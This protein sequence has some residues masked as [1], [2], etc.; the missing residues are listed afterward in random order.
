MF[1][2]WSGYSNRIQVVAEGQSGKFYAL[3]PT[4]WK[5]YH[6]YS[7]H[8]RENYDPFGYHAVQV[9]LNVLRHTEHE[10]MQRIFVFEKFWAHKYNLPPE[11]WATL[12]DTPK[13]PRTYYHLR[14]VHLQDGTLI[15]DNAAWNAQHTAQ[16]MLRNPR[17][18]RSRPGYRFALNPPTQA[19]I[20]DESLSAETR[21]PR[22]SIMHSGN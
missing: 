13:A 1:C 2:G 19:G 7:N 9:G 5:E 14:S 3:T 15:Q 8:G 20:G 18:V 16:M 6:P 22:V 4:P 10:P 21:A 11:L 17:L 12:Y